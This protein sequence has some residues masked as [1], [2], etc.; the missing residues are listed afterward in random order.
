VPLPAPHF[1]ASPLQ[2]G[3]YSQIDASALI[4]ASQR[5]NAPVVAVL[6]DTKGGLPN[7]ALPFTN[8][9]VLRNVLR[10]GVAYD[11]ARAAFMGGA[12]KVIVVRA[13][14]PTRSSAIL[15]GTTGT[16]VTLTSLDYGVWTAQ[17]K[18]TVEANNK[19][20]IS[21]TDA[22]GFTYN[23][24]YAMGAAA[25]AQQLTDAINGLNPQFPKSQ[26]VSAVNN[27]TGTMPLVTAV[28]AVLTTPGIDSIALVA[29]D[30][31]AALVKLE[32]EDVDII[33]PATGDATV[34]A[35]VIAHSDLM[36]APQARQERTQVLGG[37]A[38]ESV[39][40][41]AARMTTLRNKRVQL[42][43]PGVSLFDDTG[44]LIAYPP[45]VLAGFT[46]G[47]HAALPDVATSLV[48]SN[49]GS[50]VVDVEARLS[51]IPGGDLDVLLA[52]GVSPL[53]VDPSG[54]FRYVDSLSGYIA[55]FSFRDF[56][57]IRAAD[58]SAVMLRTELE[59]QFVGRKTGGL[60]DE[61]RGAANAILD[62]LVLMGII[63]GHQSADAIPDPVYPATTY[64][65]API[66]LPDTSKFVLLTVALQPASS[67]T[68]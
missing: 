41:V 52:A 4:A 34:H 50:Q 48:H 19:V 28:I 51:T 31:T 23:E 64:V 37:L 60:T 3:A 9:G 22:L 68:V 57:K 59:N 30:W 35:Q 66:V 38:A 1:A 56:H 14:A 67:L 53:G 6:G 32:T 36:S 16:P 44:T 47:R 21:Y 49:L 15:S 45:Y 8:V 10:S 58:F 63:V 11:T 62:R 7:V 5:V 18:R 27:G 40:T 55:D 42:V 24:I 26:Y 2:P 20:T 65:Q 61:I 43:Y 39:A 13:G 54:G 33:V 17:I 29:G 12:A 46:A 25:T